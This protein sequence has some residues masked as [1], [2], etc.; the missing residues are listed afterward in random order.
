MIAKPGIIAADAYISYGPGAISENANSEDEEKELCSMWNRALVQNWMESV[1]DKTDELKTLDIF[2]EQQTK[3]IEA[4]YQ[5]SITTVIRA[6]HLTDE[7][8]AL[9][10]PVQEVMASKNKFNRKRDT[11][12]KPFRDQAGRVLLDVDMVVELKELEDVY[13]AEVHAWTRKMLC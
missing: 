12:V 13:H 7:M 1:D 2:L 6:H 9:A 8:L 4:A 10:F 11:R 3:R 5:E